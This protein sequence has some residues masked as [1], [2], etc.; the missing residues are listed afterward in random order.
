MLIEFWRLWPLLARRESD[1]CESDQLKTLELREMLRHGAALD[2]RASRVR[3]MRVAN[4]TVGEQCGNGAAAG[5]AERPALGGSRISADRAATAVIKRIT[6][7]STN[8]IASGP[9][10]G[11]REDLADTAIEPKRHKSGDDAMM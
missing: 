8:A 2:L 10:F 5:Q 1:S 4:W 11:S 6:V 9:S 3:R 7:P